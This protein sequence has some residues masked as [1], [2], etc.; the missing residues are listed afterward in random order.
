MDSSDRWKWAGWASPEGAS[1]PTLP[2]KDGAKD[3]VEW[4]IFGRTMIKKTQGVIATLKDIEGKSDVTIAHEAI[5]NIV[6]SAINTNFVATFVRLR[7]ILVDVGQYC[8]E[9][10]PNAFFEVLHKIKIF[11]L[12]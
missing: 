9:I 4:N 7:R 3:L 11:P 8:A 2:V 10:F 12:F 1:Q 6:A 5:E